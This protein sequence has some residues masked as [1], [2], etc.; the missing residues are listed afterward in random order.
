MIPGAGYGVVFAE[1]LAA[2]VTRRM[3]DATSLRLSLATETQGR[4][5]G[6]TLS[7]ATALARGGLEVRGGELRKR[8]IAFSTWHIG[9]PNGPAT[10]FA[11]VPRAELVA[12]HR[13]TAVPNIVTGIPMSRVGAAF[14]RMAGPWVG[15]LIGERRRGDPTRPCRVHRRPR[16]RPCAYASRRKPVAPAARPSPRS[17]KLAKGTERRR[18][19]RS[20]R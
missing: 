8:S 1:C 4:S 16:S 10:S 12:V 11:A 7:V 13:S 14:V 2:Y 3:P 19:R 18:P 5:R 15:K 6:A 9:Y 17:W 20:G